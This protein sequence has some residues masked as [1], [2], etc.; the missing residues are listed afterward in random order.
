MNRAMVRSKIKKMIVILIGLAILAIVIAVIYIIETE[1]A[2]FRRNAEFAH[3]MPTTNLDSKDLV[4]YFSRSGNTELMAMEIAKYYQAS[5]VHLEA[6]DYRIGF[7]GCINALR[8][9]QTQHAMIT[10]EKIDLSQYDTI[11]IGSPIWWYSPAPPVWQFIKNNDFTGKN[12]VLFTT[13]NS[14][15]KQ[16]YIDEFKAKVEAKNG[17][18]VKHIYVERGRITQQISPETLLEQTRKELNKLQH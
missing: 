7:R 2:Q 14:R 1:K 6:K 3:Y 17:H 10:P 18:F 15:Y 4:M 5:L 8:D 12:V 16:E 11:F 9:S 13:F